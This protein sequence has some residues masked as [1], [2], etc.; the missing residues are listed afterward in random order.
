MSGKAITLP[1]TTATTTT[2]VRGFRVGVRLV[3]ARA[4]RA[5]VEVRPSSPVCLALMSASRRR[6]QVPYG[7]ELGPLAFD[8][9]KFFEH[10]RF[11]KD[12]LVAYGD[13]N[14]RVLIY[15]P[16]QNEVGEFASRLTL[17]EVYNERYHESIEPPASRYRRSPP[18]SSSCP[19]T[20]DN[21]SRHAAQSRLFL[22]ASTRVFRK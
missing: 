20:G 16:I 21:L 13:E 18:A 5:D 9:F 2:L 10:P 3:H 22:D 15:D 1:T 19:R 7:R 17:N 8:R 14:D 12:V 11:V 4:N 6:A